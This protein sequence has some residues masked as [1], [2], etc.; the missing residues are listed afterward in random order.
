MFAPTVCVWPN[1]F[2]A[3]VPFIHVPFFVTRFFAACQFLT[4]ALFVTASVDSFC[5]PETRYAFENI[6]KTCRKTSRKTSRQTGFE[7]G[8]KTGGEIRC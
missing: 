2:L 3:R 6:Q 7:T 4:G 1:I 8:R 5:Q